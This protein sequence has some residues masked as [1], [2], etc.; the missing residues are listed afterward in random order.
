MDSKRMVDALLE[1]DPG[2]E[3]LCKTL[4]GDLVEPADVWDFMYTPDGISK[5]APVVRKAMPDQADLATKGGRFVRSLRRH[6]P[7]ASAGAAA[8][9]GSVA[10]AKR[11]DKPAQFV[12]IDRTGEHVLKSDTPEVVWEG[13]FS[14]TDDDKRQAFGWAS[15]VEVD[16]KPIVDRQ[17]DWITPDEI[18]KAAYKYVLE[19]RKGGS[20]HKRNDDDTPLHASSL[21]ESFVVTPEK[22][23]KMGLPASTPVGWWVGFSFHD[24][25]TWQDIKK[26]L[27][28]GFSLHGKGKR[29]DVMPGA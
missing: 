3:Q 28:T 25:D 10:Y 9:A 8:G 16:G 2:F 24:E 22:I 27:K 20:Q 29:S 1:V 11:P 6:A 21:I 18:E 23:E 7:A 15:V 12:R 17:G 14:K 19:N 4:F 13:T 5:M 26:G